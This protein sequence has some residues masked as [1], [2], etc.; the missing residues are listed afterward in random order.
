MSLPIVDLAQFPCF[1]HSIVYR[2]L[3]IFGINFGLM[4]P[5]FIFSFSRFQCT[6]NIFFVIVVAPIFKL[7]SL[8]IRSSLQVYRNS[9]G[10]VINHLLIFE[11]MKA[12]LKCEVAIDSVDIKKLMKIRTRRNRGIFT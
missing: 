2:F 9:I 8:A 11:T 6:A 3:S 12:N 4:I 7:C 5:I 10:Y 1:Y